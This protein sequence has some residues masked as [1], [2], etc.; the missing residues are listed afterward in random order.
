MACFA[1]LAF[2]SGFKLYAPSSSL[3][4]DESSFARIESLSNIVKSKSL[5]K[6]GWSDV[7]LGQGFKRKDQLYT[8][9][10]SKAVLTL[11]KD[12]NLTLLPNTLVELDQLSGGLALQVKE[13][14][15]YLDIRSGEAVKIR[16]EGRE[17]TLRGDNAR[18]KLSQ[19]QGKSRLESSQGTI[20][21]SSED[22]KIAKLDSSN[23]I[24]VSAANKLKVKKNTAFLKSPLD[25]EIFSTE[26]SLVDIFFEW[27]LLEEP[28]HQ[29][30]VQ[31]SQDPF[32]KDYQEIESQKA[33]LGLGTY[34][35]RLVSDEEI[36]PSQ[37]YSFEI[38]EDLKPLLAEQEK[39]ELIEP[40]DNQQI[41]L[42]NPGDTIIFKFKGSGVVEI[43]SQEDFSNVK[44]SSE[45]NDR[46]EWAVDQTGVFYW[47]VKVQDQY[48]PIRKI[49][50]MPGEILPPPEFDRA[51]SEI[52]LKVLETSSWLKSFINDAYAQEFAAEFEWT[53]VN[54]AKSYLIEIYSD[55]QG[56]KLIKK[57]TTLSENYQW[58]GAPL[59]TVWWRVSAVD[60]WGREGQASKIIKTTLMPPSGWES[61]EV[62]LAAPA[63]GSEAEQA[64]RVLFEW[65]NSPG[66]TKWTWLLSPDLSFAKPKIVHSAKK[67]EI[68]LENMPEGV[69]Y[70]KV[71]ATDKLGRV[72]ESRR[73]R[74]KITVPEPE[75]VAKRERRRIQ[76]QSRLNLRSP[77]DIELGLLISKPS[78]ELTRGSQK[79]NLSGFSASGFHLNLSR[80]WGKWR[81]LVNLDWISGKAF[82]S[83][84]YQDAKLEVAA[85]KPFDINWS[86]PI[87]AGA[88]LNYTRLSSYQRAANS[89][90][91]SEES[92]S[93]IGIVAFASAEP[94]KWES[95][96]LQSNV[97]ISGPSRL[98]LGFE[99]RHVLR[100]WYWGAGF[101]R[102]SLEDNGE[103]SV[104]TM[105]L[106][107]GYRWQRQKE[108]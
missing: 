70:W 92:L 59:R 45:V 9:K 106:N 82:E 69:W 32:F 47:R 44:R 78:Y 57:D 28:T 37:I 67:N 103:V 48:S 91:L 81:G 58:I 65:E 60:G 68:V 98:T 36:I 97:Y 56:T 1:T 79:F 76:Y 10:D 52:N 24:E 14:L 12:E 62:A 39:I 42:S 99:L 77:F 83:L 107:I 25:G 86:F 6:L 102:S 7:N 101:E 35:W 50:I 29:V 27:E 61:T 13:G 108:K 88:G 22:G 30:L 90:D 75:V 26:T 105:M 49:H 93:S 8:Y 80:E 11:G 104:T 16:L 94:L 73:R 63:H 84:G 2:W 89:N 15:V 4:S 34:F 55:S 38:K 23:S 18:V 20:D 96:Y 64:E 3:D 54:G 33:S 17:L 41:N 31:V 5:G 43:S 72:V 19:S 46:Y 53:Q 85:E 21:I 100:N 51:P 95:S 71:R 40:Q 87:W 74:I 66:V